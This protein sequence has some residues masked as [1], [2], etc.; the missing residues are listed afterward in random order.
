M[1]LVALVLAVPARAHDPMSSWATLQPT[2]DAV[3]VEADMAVEA[4]MALLGVPMGSAPAPADASTLVAPLT[5]QVQAGNLYRLMAGT[6]APLRLQAVDVE[7]REDDGVAF[8]L[9]FAPLAVAELTVEAPFL[10]LLAAEHKSALTLLAPDGRVQS[11]VILRGGRAATQFA[12]PGLP[13]SAASDAEADSGAPTAPRRTEGLFRTYLLLG[14]EHILTGYDHLLFLLALLVACRR[15][16]SAVAII[17]CF[18]IGQ[19]LTLGLAALEIVTVPP[20][21]VE[22]LIAASIVFVGVENLL[23]RDE[24]KARWL[25]TLGFGLIHGFGFAGV[26]REIGFGGAGGGIAVPLLA[27]NL[28]VELGQLAVATLALPV[29][30]ALRRRPAL[31]RCEVPAVSTVVVALGLFWLVQRLTLAA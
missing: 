31:A 28:G 23:R 5:A 4:A 21:V 25:L 16:R 18:T 6:G 3:I 13:P 12:V 7:M 9:E 14:I 8:L 26:L 15:L 24:P 22:P 1:A 17:T 20:R 19:S 29:L 27:F 2:P 30:L 10:H 11:S